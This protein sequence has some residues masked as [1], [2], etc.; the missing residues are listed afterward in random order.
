MGSRFFPTQ[1]GHALR[2]KRHMDMGIIKRQEIDTSETPTWLIQGD[3][4]WQLTAATLVAMQSVP[5]LVCMYAGIVKKKWAINSAFMAFY[6]F[7]AVLICWTVWAYKM[8][9][10]TQWGSFPLLGVPGPVISMDWELRASTLP[11]ANVTEN[12]NQATMVYFQ[13]VFAAITVVL[14]AGSLLGRMNFLAWMVF[15]PLWLTFSYTVGAF[16][17]WGGGFL[18]TLGVIDYSGGYVIH[19]SSGTA[20]FVAAYWLGISFPF[21]SSF[22]SFFS[23]HILT[24]LF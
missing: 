16:S 10:G 12:Y 21:P 5:G 19:V 22:S 9:F 2:M 7:A 4:A 23:K 6:A 15:V 18:Y 17:V 1:E 20:G 8:A 24:G 14:I 11:A 3:Q 13:F